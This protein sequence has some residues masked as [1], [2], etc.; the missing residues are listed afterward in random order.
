[1]SKEINLRDSAQARNYIKEFVQTYRAST[2]L[3]IEF[4][5]TTCQRRIMLNAMNDDDA[6]FVAHQFAGMEAEAN[7]A[8][9]Q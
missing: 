8:R 3:L 7:Q 9:V 6:V 2:G 5:D 4:I 1:M